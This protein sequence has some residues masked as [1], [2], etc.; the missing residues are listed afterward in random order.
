MIKFFR[1]IN[2]RSFSIWFSQVWFGQV[3]FG[4]L[5]FVWRFSLWWRKEKKIDFPIFFSF[6]ISEV[7][8]RVFI[9]R[10]VLSFRPRMLLTPPPRLCMSPS[11][12]SRMHRNIRCI[13]CYLHRRIWLNFQNHRNS[14]ILSLLL[15]SPRFRLFLFISPFFLFYW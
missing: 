13:L 3:W 1:S 9:E 5:K 8:S 4:K 10:A 15:Y 6:S 7:V 11:F 14:G 2:N 12:Q